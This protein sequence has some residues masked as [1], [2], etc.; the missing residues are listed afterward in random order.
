M[1]TISFNATLINQA[2]LHSTIISSAI[3]YNGITDDGIDIIGVQ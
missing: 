2:S 1:M 3:E